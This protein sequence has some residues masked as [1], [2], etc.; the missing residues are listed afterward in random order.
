MDRKV[1]PFNK[2][3]G[4]KL[5]ES[6]I[7]IECEWAEECKKKVID[8]LKRETGTDFT[9]EGLAKFV[10]FKHNLLGKDNSITS[11]QLIDHIKDLIFSHYGEDLYLSGQY[12]NMMLHSQGVIVSEI[13]SN[14]MSAMLG[15]DEKVDDTIRVFDPRKEYALPEDDS[16]E[17]KK[18]RVKG[19]RDYEKMLNEAETSLKLENYDEIVEQLI[20][21]IDPNTTKEDILDFVTDYI[22]AHGRICTDGL[23]PSDAEIM[24]KIGITLWSEKITKEIM[25]TISS[26]R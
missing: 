15:T 20:E 23:E 21:M 24:I 14:I 11:L 19:Y 22:R 6:T 12:D 16:N 9:W 7:S 18:C 17:N 4:E 10:R 3:R 8:D 26:I 1:K 2:F 13:A 5:D 25:D